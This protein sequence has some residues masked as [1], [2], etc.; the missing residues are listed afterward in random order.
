MLRR[1][2]HSQTQ[3]SRKAERRQKAH[4]AHRPR[5]H[6]AG[7]VPGGAESGGGRVILAASRDCA[8]A[9]YRL[10]GRFI[11]LVLSRGAV[12]DPVLEASITRGLFVSYSSSLE[13]CRVT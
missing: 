3:A 8:S 11:I 6:S 5:G 7:G 12:P 4:E 1:R 13:R 9:I 2:H 10:R